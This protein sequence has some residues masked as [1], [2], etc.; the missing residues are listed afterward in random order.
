MNSFCL[1]PLRTVVDEVTECRGS[2]HGFAQSDCQQGPSVHVPLV[3]R[4]HL[5]NANWLSEV[6]DRTYIPAD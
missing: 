5:L 6:S 2:Q 1:V 3:P 4:L